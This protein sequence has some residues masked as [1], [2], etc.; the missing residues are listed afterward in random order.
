RGQ[1][2][3][4][5]RPDRRPREQ[6]HD[7][8]RPP[9]RAAAAALLLVAAAKFPAFTAP[10]V[11]E[12]GVVPAASEQQLDAALQDYQSRSGNQI[13]VAVVKNTDGQSLEDYSIDLARRWGVGTKEKD[14][15]VLLLIVW[16]KHELRIEVGRRLEGQ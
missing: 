1:H 15:G 6:P 3:G 14:N 11:D 9:V 5:Q 12:A 13:A 2:A 10:V 7:E 4:P 16:D 8:H